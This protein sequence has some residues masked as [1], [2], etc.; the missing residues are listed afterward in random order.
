[1][2]AIDPEAIANFSQ[3]YKDGKLK[4]SELEVTGNATI[5]PAYIG[6][7]NNNDG[8]WAQFS[9]KDKKGNSQY[10]VLGGKNGQT[11]INSSNN[12]K[13]RHNN[14]DKAGVD[15]SGNI[16]ANKI[17][18]PHNWGIDINNDNKQ[19]YIGTHGLEYKD[20]WINAKYLYGATEV[21]SG[22]KLVGTNIEGT[23]IKKGGKNVVAHNENIRIRTSEKNRHRSFWDNYWYLE[24]QH[25][26]GS[27]ARRTSPTK[28]GIFRLV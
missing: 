28:D 13:F 14:S 24:L 10:S 22:S 20:A 26:N 4:I 17:L 6:H 18:L 3:M 1:M 9:H 8:N 21:K 12:I 25:G 16:S 15:S 23:S 27:T 19:M 2:S 7:Y 11:L 5:G